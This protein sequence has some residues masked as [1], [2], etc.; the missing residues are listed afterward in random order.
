VP[1]PVPTNIVSRKTHGAAGPFDID[2]KA[3]A[4]GIECRTGGG[5]GDHTIVVTFAG[6]TTVVGDG[7]VKAKV[8]SGAGQ[9]GSGGIANGNAVTTSGN[10]VTVSLTNVANAQRLAITLYGVNDS[11]LSG[12]VVV[13]LNTLLGDVNGNSSVTGTDVAQT[14]A[15]SGLPVGASNFRSD[16]IVSGAINATDVA[17]VK[18]ASGTVLPTP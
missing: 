16:V 6:P 18:S 9:V 4:P 7:S 10:T 17:V 5:T 12:D 2:L 3:P 1:V 13:P 8:T 15:N 14:K 11:T